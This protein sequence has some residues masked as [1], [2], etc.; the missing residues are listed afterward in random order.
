MTIS[1]CYS[2]EH[3]LV[4][5]SASCQSN[6]EQVDKMIIFS[7]SISVHNKNT[8][9]ADVEKERKEGQPCREEH[10]KVPRLLRAVTQ[11]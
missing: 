1:S 7:E 8:G 11:P 4:Y 2:G 3:A 6:L 10:K 5:T 9:V